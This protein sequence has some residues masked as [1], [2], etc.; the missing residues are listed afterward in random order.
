MMGI[1]SEWRAKR[2]KKFE[3][4]CWLASK[5]HE[6]NLAVEQAV[7]DEAITP[8]Q[9]NILILRFGLRDGKKRSIAQVAKMVNKK[10]SGMLGAEKEVDLSLW[11]ARHALR[12]KQY[13]VLDLD[14]DEIEKK[15]LAQ[16]GYEDMHATEIKEL[17]D[18]RSLD[19]L[20]RVSEMEKRVL[21]KEITNID[22]DA[23]ELYEELQ[24]R[25][26]DKTWAQ[27]S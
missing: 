25:V 23:R 19:Q 3:R 17:E 18:S 27:P 1:L 13:K 16:I 26:A 7:R 15:A 11:A 2:R 10:L 6:L 20:R 12:R 5:R 24:K 21:A 8:D 14:I 4:V 22:T 9:A